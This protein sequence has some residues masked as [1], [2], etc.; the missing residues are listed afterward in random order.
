MGGAAPVRAAGY[1]AA[2]DHQFLPGGVFAES[3]AYALTRAGAEPD[4]AAALIAQL[5]AAAQ[6]GLE[7]EVGQRILAIFGGNDPLIPIHGST[8]RLRETAE[9]TARLQQI[10]VF[11][12]AG[13]RLQAGTSPAP[14]YLACLSTWSREL[15]ARL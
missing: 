3:E 15:R 11:P 13:H 8:A 14:G 7:Y 1:P 5:T 12:G 10:T 4:K 2:S 9:R 6:A